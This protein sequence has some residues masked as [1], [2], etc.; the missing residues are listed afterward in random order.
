MTSSKNDSLLN[1]KKVKVYSGQHLIP[2][3]NSTVLKRYK[4]SFRFLVKNLY[5]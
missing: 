3:L 1:N 4:Y 2:C 5:P